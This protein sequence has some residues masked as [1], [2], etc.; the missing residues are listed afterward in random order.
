MT[1]LF[2]TK[3]NSASDS[4]LG[5]GPPVGYSCAGALSNFGCYCNEFAFSNHA[6]E[7][8]LT[9]SF[10]GVVSMNVAVLFTMLAALYSAQVVALCDQSVLIDFRNRDVA[11][12]WNAVNDGVM[13][14]RSV[15]KS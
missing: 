11:S 9:L 2:V 3:S 14:R 4:Y 8:D 1:S 12:Q 5:D 13:G 10:W 7:C 15:G 6:N